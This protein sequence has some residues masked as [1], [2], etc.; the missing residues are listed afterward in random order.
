M[1]RRFEVE[2]VNGE[3]VLFANSTFN[4]WEVWTGV[5]STNAPTRTTNTIGFDDNY[6]ATSLLYAYIA[7]TDTWVATTQTF[8]G[9]IGL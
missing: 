2:T 6:S 7:D 8:Y 3:E 9:F 1:A 4:K 5:G